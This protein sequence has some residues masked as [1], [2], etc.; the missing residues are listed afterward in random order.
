[1]PL[2]LK[3]EG[4]EGSNE[5]LWICR[6]APHWI[7]RRSGVQVPLSLLTFSSFS[8]IKC[9]EA[10]P[11]WD[12]ASTAIYPPRKKVVRRVV[13]P[14]DLLHEGGTKL[15]ASPYFVARYGDPWALQQG[16]G[17]P[18]SRDLLVPYHSASR[19]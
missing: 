16:A 15:S 17:S 10:T 6:I 8:L 12:V 5:G 1:M 18:Q 4:M 7:I 19:L 11:R 9:V 14:H 3:S 2:L 13:S